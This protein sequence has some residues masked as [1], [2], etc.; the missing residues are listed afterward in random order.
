[1]TKPLTPEAM[2]H[3][4]ILQGK[5]T[6]DILEAMAKSHPEFAITNRMVSFHRT[7]LRK[8]GH[9]IE[10][11]GRNDKGT[12]RGA[13]KRTTATKPKTPAKKAAVKKA[14]V[15]KAAAKKPAAKRPAAKKP[16]AKKPA[17]K[18]APVKKA[19][20]K[21]PAAKRP[22]AKKPAARKPAASKTTAKT[23]KRGAKK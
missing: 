8:L 16:A 6:N 9:K 1:M 20:A 3:S 5:S 23:S 4:L 2:I 15:K 11:A 13:N 19:A 12:T 10:R 22:A 17:V 14:P 7:L 21:K 18:K